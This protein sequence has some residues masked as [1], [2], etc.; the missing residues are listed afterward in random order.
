[1]RIRTAITAAALLAS[2][3]GCGSGGDTAGS[4]AKPSASSSG[5]DAGEQFLADV[6]ARQF[7]S[8]ATDGPT[9]QEL[10]ML[11]PEW[12]LELKDGHSVEYLLGKSA[13]AYPNGPE[14]GTTRADANELLLL[15]VSTHCPKLRDQ[16]TEELRETGQY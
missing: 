12:C 8:W 1:M 13:E 11:P 7:E 6:H 3:V 4:D 9:D 5:P 10:L 15:G 14:W 16:V 2:L